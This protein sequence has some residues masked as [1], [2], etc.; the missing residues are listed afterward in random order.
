M[1]FIKRFNPLA[2]VVVIVTTIA[3]VLL[4]NFVLTAYFPQLPR[5]VSDFSPAYLQRQIA[6]TAATAGQTVFLGDSVLWGYRLKPDQTMVSILAS[7]GCA[8]RNFAFKNGGPPNYYALTRLMLAA[9]T[10]PTAVVLEINQ[11]VFSQL[12]GGNH[13][14]HPAVETLAAPLLTLSD[15][16]LLPASSPS[17]NAAERTLDRS[18]TSLSLLYAMRSDIRTV[19]YGEPATSAIAPLNADMLEGTYDLTPLSDSN[20][21]VHFLEKTVQL[22]RAANIPVIAFL[23]PTNHAL[24]HDY[25]DNPEYRAN[26]L[27]LK[28]MLEREG[29]HVLDLDAAFPTQ[30]FLDE[31]H[32]TASAQLRLADIISKELK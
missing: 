18:A 27:F 16:A 25:I 26:G 20:V 8:C 11:K 10:H 6:S 4:Q 22:L 21:S 31:V 19:L 32:L 15:R 7:R 23:T 17:G 12:D 28:Q 13:S 14:L 9:K 5:F 29:V 3:V 2:I 30:A 1:L 24:L